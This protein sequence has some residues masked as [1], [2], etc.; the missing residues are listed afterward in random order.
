M[1]YN[2][3][4]ISGFSDEEGMEGEKVLKPGKVMSNFAL[5]AAET[6]ELSES[7]TINT[8]RILV[9]EKRLDDE[10]TNFEHI[11]LDVE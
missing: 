10:I 4:P 11:F 8:E 6:K 2:V 9:N 7:I 5:I 1:S 3:Q